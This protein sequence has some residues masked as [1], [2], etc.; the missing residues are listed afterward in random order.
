MSA[1]PLTHHEIL[2]L[3][4]P[5]ARRGRHVDLAASDRMARRIAFRAVDHA[6]AD[7]L[8]AMRESLELEHGGT[9]Y[10]SLTRLLAV[11]GGLQAKLV[12]EGRTPAAVLECVEAVP[13]S[14]QVAAS[15]G[16]L[17]VRG[18]RA[19]PAGGADAVRL[20]LVEAQAQVDGVALALRVPRTSGMPADLELAGSG[21]PLELPEDFLAVLGWPWTRIAFTRGRWSGSLRLRGSGAARTADA[22]RKFERTVQHVAA[23]LALPP[24]RFHEGRRLARWGV[25][26][27]R[28]VPLA[29]CF[30]MLAGTAALSSLDLEENSVWRMLMFHAP[31]LLLLLFVALPEMPRIE[32]PPVP[33]RLT[34]PSWRTRPS[35][36]AAAGEQCPATR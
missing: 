19:E 11:E 3:V 21:D 30:A 13:R 32:I 36:T 29:A 15:P 34:A 8:P 1:R 2:A 12:A 22:E 4:E 24:A 20:T 10:Y 25:T 5:Y 6:A 17:V 28:A 9:D 18:Y 35:D 31:P 26:L 27:R 14:R 7:G 33:R 23:T 16:A